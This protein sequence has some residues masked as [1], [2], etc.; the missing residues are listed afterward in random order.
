MPPRMQKPVNSASSSSFPN[1]DMDKLSKDGK[2]I[3]AAMN[4]KFD[5]MKREFETMKEELLETI[6]EKDQEILDLTN[7]VRSLK[8]KV[9]R[10]EDHLD[11]EDAYVRRETILF[12]GSSIPEVSNGEI[13]SNVIRQ[14]VK[15]K[16]KITLKDGDISTAHRLGKKPTSQVPDKRSIIVKLCRRDTKQEIFAAKRAM[17]PGNSSSTLFINES[18]TARR[19]TILYAL[20]QMKRAH[21][22]IILGCSSYDGR[23]YAYT[24]PPVQASQ[25]SP[26]RN[27]RHLIN[28]HESLTEFCRE[29]IKQP[30]D[31][32]LDSWSH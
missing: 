24:K 15:E 22:S 3:I 9:S 31:T 4:L 1:L 19:R 23:V 32:F 27:V 29:H 2:M 12:S 5:E 18:L 17:T 13:C 16:L 30:L 25:S 10:L 28:N 11:E 21:P 7:E 26:S 14:I 6:S 8:K 20:R